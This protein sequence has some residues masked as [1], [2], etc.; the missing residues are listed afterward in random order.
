MVRLAAPVSTRAFLKSSDA[1]ALV[2]LRISVVGA[3]LALPQVM[4][5]PVPVPLPPRSTATDVPAAEK[6][7]T[8]PVM[9]TFPLAVPSVRVKVGAGD[10]KAPPFMVMS[11][12]AGMLAPSAGR[13]TPPVRAGAG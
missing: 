9:R 2:A 12:L 13:G 8:P 11:E 6:P 10:S 3:K 1:V 4:A 7:L 5:G